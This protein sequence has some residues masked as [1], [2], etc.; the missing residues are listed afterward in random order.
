MLP[1]RSGIEVFIY[2]VN[3]FKL[4]LHS[5]GLSVV[6]FVFF[7]LFF[8]GFVL[9]SFRCSLISLN[10]CQVLTT[11]VCR[12]LVPLLHQLNGSDFWPPIFLQP[13]NASEMESTSYLLP[14]QLFNNMRFL[15]DN[16][17]QERMMVYF[18]K[19][20]MLPKVEME[21]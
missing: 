6:F 9:F 21:N 4:V 14:Y 20:E 12:S 2:S 18:S 3:T 16:E 11:F 8:F 10:A 7:F 19:Y 17:V 15:R 5:R 1:R 13:Y